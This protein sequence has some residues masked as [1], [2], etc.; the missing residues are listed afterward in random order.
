[1]PSSAFRRELAMTTDRAPYTEAEQKAREDEA[2]AAAKH[3]AYDRAAA[4]WR[5]LG[6]PGVAAWVYRNAAHE[7]QLEQD[8]LDGAKPWVHGSRLGREHRS[9][10]QHM[11]EDHG[12]TKDELKGV[13]DAGV[14][15][16]HNRLHDKT[17]AYAFDLPHP[18]IKQ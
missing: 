5:D 12:L 13:S 14:D 2:R 15:G 18:E 4:I 3:G 17:W 8:E 9:L 6:Q 11:C 10:R 7:A 1:M 16:W